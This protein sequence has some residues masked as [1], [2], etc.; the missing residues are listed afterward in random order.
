MSVMKTKTSLHQA[1]RQVLNGIIAQ[2][3][4]DRVLLFGSAVNKNAPAVN[5]LDFLVVIPD[6]ASPVTIVDRLNINIRN[7]PMPCDFVVATQSMLNNR[8]TDAGSVYFAALAEGQVI[9]ARSSAIR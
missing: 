2:A 5:D 9:Y 8:R 1:V 3:D 7:K 6:S 4:P